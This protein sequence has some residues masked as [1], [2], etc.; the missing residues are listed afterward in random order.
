MQL[1]SH[2][3]PRI[4]PVGPGGVARERDLTSRLTVDEIEDAWSAIETPAG[5]ALPKVRKGIGLDDAD[6][7]QAIKDLMCPS[8][9]EKLRDTRPLESHR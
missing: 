9:D 8:S 2:G 1:L 6:T 7:V 3:G 5:R 4:H